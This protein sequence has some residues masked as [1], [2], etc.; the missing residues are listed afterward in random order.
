MNAIRVAT[1]TIQHSINRLITCE[2]AMAKERL[3]SVKTTV[4]A[5]ATA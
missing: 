2:I 4:Q 1:E 5:I 3:A